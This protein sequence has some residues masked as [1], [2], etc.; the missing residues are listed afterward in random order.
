MAVGDILRFVRKVEIDGQLHVN[1]LHFLDN[2]VTPTPPNTTVE[3]E[4]LRTWDRSVDTTGPENL[5]RQLF[6][7]YTTIVQVSLSAQIIF[8]AKEEIFERAFDTGVSSALDSGLPTFSQTKVNISTTRQD[9]SGRGGFYVGGIAEQHTDGNFVNA[10]YQTLQTNFID[11]LG[12]YYTVGGADYDGFVLGVWSTLLNEWNPWQT[13]AAASDLG[14]M[15][16]RRS[17]RGV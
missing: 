11:A 5:Y 10:A 4:L 7:G 6:R 12:R 15:R 1:V 8:P 14:T 3:E 2:G 16:S 17:G 13:I 9:R